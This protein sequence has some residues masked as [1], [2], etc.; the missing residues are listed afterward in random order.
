[1]EWTRPTLP[2]STINRAGRD[3]RAIFYEPISIADWTPEHWARYR[4]AVGVIDYW[5]A[6]H[7]YPLNTM[8]INLR[9]MARKFD[10]AVLVAQRTK[11]LLS[12]GAK[13]DRNASMK[14]TQMQDVGGC[15]AILKSVEAVRRLDQFLRKESR[16][17]H[18]FS[19][20]D[21]YILSPKRSG[22]RGIHHVYRF[23]ALKPPA[24]LHNGLK[25]EI[26]I[27]TQFQHAWATTVE[28]VGTFLGQALKAS[29]GS[30]DWLRFFA[31]TG[32]AIAIREKT[33]IVPGTP[34]NTK[35]LVAELDDLAY[36]LNVENRLRGYATAI[37]TMEKQVQN[38]HYFLLELDPTPMLPVLSVTGFL[39]EKTEEAHK[40]YAEAEIRVKERPG[41][42][43]V[44]VS[45]D[46]ITNL[47]HAYPNYYADTRVFLDLL[48]Q[49]LSGQ[50]RQIRV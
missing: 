7:A 9:R 45:V 35:E 19:T 38:A 12:I 47:S 36:K 28:T 49:A 3:Y 41:T 23:K 14:L 39:R 18:E 31:L 8:Q 32:S 20:C 22:Y 26:Q 2:L 37:Q 46:S 6:C 13:L 30:D 16:M 11:R 40:A 50:Q 5:R 15:R 29:I 34:Q 1:M 42:D 24:S 27:R 10:K 21:D 25:I 48:A 44:L 33:V 4:Q 43:A 17:N